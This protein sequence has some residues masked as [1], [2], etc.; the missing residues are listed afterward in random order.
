MKIRVRNDKSNWNKNKEKLFKSISPT[1]RE[2]ILVN[3]KRF[4][5]GCAIVWTKG[6]DADREEYVDMIGECW[7]DLCV[8][9]V[10]FYFNHVIVW[11]ITK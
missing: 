3:K 7:N 1:K 5:L 4:K 11:Y 9:W 10:D 2:T 8:N 6:M